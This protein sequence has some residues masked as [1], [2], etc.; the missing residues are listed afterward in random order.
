MSMGDVVH[1]IGTALE[2]LTGESANRPIGSRDSS[3][4]TRNKQGEHA[5]AESETML[6][7]SRYDDFL[8]T[9]DLAER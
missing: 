9:D 6:R 8:L 1:I 2:T 4:C 7:F 3:F 5:P